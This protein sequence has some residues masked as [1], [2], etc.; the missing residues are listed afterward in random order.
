[1]VINLRCLIIGHRYETVGATDEHAIFWRCRRC[2]YVVH[3]PPRGIGEYAEGAPQAER[4]GKKYF[5]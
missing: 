2:T 5:E 4:W 3:K 1:M